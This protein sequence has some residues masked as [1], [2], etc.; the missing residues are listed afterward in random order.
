MTDK[1]YSTKNTRGANKMAK[2]KSIPLSMICYNNPFD[3]LSWIIVNFKH[4]KKFGY[5]PSQIFKNNRIS[6]KP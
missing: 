3:P 6:V 1:N 2:R 5:T 4:L